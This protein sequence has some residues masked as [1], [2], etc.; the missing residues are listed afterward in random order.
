MSLR[1]LRIFSS[2]LYLFTYLLHVAWCYFIANHGKI[3]TLTN[4]AA[5]FH[6]IY[7]NAGFH[8]SGSGAYVVSAAI[9]ST[10]VLNAVRRACEA[11]SHGWPRFKSHDAG[12]MFMSWMR[13]FLYGILVFFVLGILGEKYSKTLDFIDVFFIA[14]GTFL[15]GAIVD[16][17]DDAIAS[18]IVCLSRTN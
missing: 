13:F 1:R 14:G 3:S 15:F 11:M 5:W 7:E 9:P 2:L 17:V 18:S 10:L 16:V 12:T 8:W 4:M 6:K